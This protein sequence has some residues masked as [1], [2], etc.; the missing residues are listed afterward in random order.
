MIWATN[1]AE[2]CV[3]LTIERGWF[4]DRYERWLADAWSRLLLANPSP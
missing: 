3:L 1:S 4:P 2:L